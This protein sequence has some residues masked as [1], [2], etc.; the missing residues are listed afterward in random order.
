MLSA[1][2][3]IDLRYCC[4][5][6]RRIVSSVF[7]SPADFLVYQNLSPKVTSPFYI[8]CFLVH[9][10][11]IHA[12][13]N[14]AESIPVQIAQKSLVPPPLL[15]PPP[16]NKNNQTLYYTIHWKFELS[17]D[18]WPNLGYLVAF[19]ADSIIFTSLWYKWV[20]FCCRIH[21][22]SFTIRC[23]GLFVQRF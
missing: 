7:D 18:G 1:C 19:S 4:G 15:P 5:H 12:C 16:K 20:I 17:W 11:P 21:Y 14:V 8:C 6:V 13:F 23:L 10:H 3:G 22:Q 9:L 2:E